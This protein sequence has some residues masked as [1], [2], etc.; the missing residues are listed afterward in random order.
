MSRVSHKLVCALAAAGLGA[1]ALSGCGG[2]GESVS[3]DDVAR[4]GDTV[5]EKSDFDK[6]LRINTRSQ[7]GAGPSVVPDPPKFTRCVEA[8][9]Q[10]PQAKGQGKPSSDQLKRLCKQ[11]YEQLKRSVM[12]FLIEAQ[13]I[14]QEAE[15][16][17]VKVSE[18]EVKRL[19]ETQRKQFYPDAESYKRF[20]RA[21]GMTE[22]EILYRMRLNALQQK[23]NAKV[24][25]GAKVKEPSEAEIRRYYNRN[26]QRFAQPELRNVN[27]VLTK[28]E[29]E[30]Q[31]AKAAVQGGQSFEQ[32]A[33]RFSID[34]LSKRQGGKLLLAKGRQSI[35][36]GPAAFT[37][38]KGELQG[39]VKTPYGYYVFEVTNITP[40]SQPSFAKAK[41]SV[42]NQLATQPRQEAVEEYEKGFREKYRAKTV[43][44]DGFEVPEC[45]NG[46]KR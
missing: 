2:D 5:I 35:G 44:A 39:P 12:R 16:Q 17:N 29:D 11:E 4:V 27:V 10:V 23:L 13:W 19:F 24:R 43:C 38:T 22:E 7:G 28:T 45:K 18:S 6:W 34:E 15:A 9:R 21:S 8:K 41:R 32:V 31:R 26:K 40:A 36:P 20:L 30:A 37:A 1:I 42:R 25:K 46:P 3:S 14:Q 33:K